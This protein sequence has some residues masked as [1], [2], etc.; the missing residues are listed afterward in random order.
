MTVTDPA[1]PLSAAEVERTCLP[2]EQATMLPGAAY[3][4][5]AVFEW[6]RANFFGKG[7]ICAGHVE[8]VAGG[9][10]S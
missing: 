10:T 1:L 7:W 2:L 5:F 3:T 8:Q 9:A 6:E 4:D